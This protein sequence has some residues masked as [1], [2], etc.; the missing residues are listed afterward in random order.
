MIVDWTRTADPA[1]QPVTRTEAKLQCKVDVTADDA[2]FDDAIIA[3]TNWIEEYL[4]RALFTQTWKVVADDWFEELWLPRAAPLQSVTTLQYYA[5][6]GTLTTLATSYY[7]TLTTGEPASIV[8]KPNQSWP[9][10]QSDRRGRVI[11]TYV[12]GWADVANIPKAIKLATLL[13]VEHFYVNRGPVVTGTTSSELA[14]S[15]EALLAP[16]RVWPKPPLVNRSW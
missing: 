1:T 8:R 15:V 13:L 10:L 3:A 12:C 4:S 2:L 14:F 16:Y 11:A 9:T 7:D 6:D 5:A